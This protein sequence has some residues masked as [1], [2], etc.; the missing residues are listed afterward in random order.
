MPDHVN[1]NWTSE[2]R[3]NAL[4]LYNSIEI[5]FLYCHF[6]KY[7]EAE[8]K[9]VSSN[10]NE[11][12]AIV[13]L[14]NSAIIAHLRC[15]WYVRWTT[16]NFDPVSEMH[17]ASVKHIQVLYGHVVNSKQDESANPYQPNILADP[18]GIVVECVLWINISLKGSS[19][20]NTR[21]F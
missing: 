21:N 20:L 15:V 5:H 9:P 7:T 17:W 3:S 12:V 10:T 18:P 1:N 6:F 8:K 13:S 14:K 16:F 4:I 11:T 2:L 19:N